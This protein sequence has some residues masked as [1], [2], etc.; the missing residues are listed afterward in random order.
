MFLIN[1]I[2]YFCER[3]HL[4]FHFYE[5]NITTISNKRYMTYEHFLGNSM[6]RAQ[7]NLNVIN[8]E[9]P[10]LTNAVDRSR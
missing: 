3:K 4:F 2:D 7:S 10:R 5:V 9:N 1:W 6:E 8:T